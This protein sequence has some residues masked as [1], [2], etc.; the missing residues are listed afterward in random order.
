MQTAGFQASRQAPAAS[1]EAQIGQLYDEIRDLV[2]RSQESPELQAS[3]EQKEKQLLALQS[4]EAK[5]WLQ[6]A[7]ARRH[8]RPGEG[9]RL[10]DRAAK[11]LES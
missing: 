7:Q 5:A 3:I 8:L 11:L 9:Y 2:A 6:Q 1:L 4:A 10:L